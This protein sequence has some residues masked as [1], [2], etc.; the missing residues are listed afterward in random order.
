MLLIGLLFAEYML[1]VIKQT[2]ENHAHQIYFYG[3]QFL[4]AALFSWFSYY[5]LGKAIFKKD[6]ALI[7]NDEGFYNNSRL[8]FSP[9]A[10]VP[11]SDVKEVRQTYMMNAN[12]VQV[13]LNNP[14]NYNYKKRL[15][16]KKSHLLL[17]N[18]IYIL[19]SLTKVRHSELVSIFRSYLRQT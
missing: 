6:P 12:W 10:F 4:L 19:S 1:E 9:A 7:F 13:V 2:Q 16:S 3:T 8:A 17:G 18:S 11:W 15:T 5:V 14:N